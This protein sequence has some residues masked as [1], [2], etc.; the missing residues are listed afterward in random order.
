MS[1]AG[2][3]LLSLF[4][5]AWGA[6]VGAL[7][8]FALLAFLSQT[9]KTTSGMALGAQDWVR[10]AVTGGL[11]VLALALFALL[12]VPALV[13]AANASFPDS[14]GCGPIT[15]LG[16]LAVRLLGA[17]GALR[18]L[19]A[20]ASAVMSTV[21]GGQASLSTALLEAGEVVL[22]MVIASVAV[23][24]AIHFFGLCSEAMPPGIACL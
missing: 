11:G 7:I 4:R 20:A 18:M 14:A 9:L 16:S 15:E 21:V 23:P 17:L 12:G 24:L 22:G 8:A 10:D 13:Q 19:K 5:D 3:L 2:D 6:L 1:N